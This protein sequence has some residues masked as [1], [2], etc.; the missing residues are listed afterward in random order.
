MHRATGKPHVCAHVFCFENVHHLTSQFPKVLECTCER[1]TRVVRQWCACFPCSG[2]LSDRAYH[3]KTHIRTL[4]PHMLKLQHTRG[5]LLGWF[6]GFGLLG[7]ALVYLLVGSMFRWFHGSLVGL[8]LLDMF[9]LVWFGLVCLDWLFAVGWL[10]WF[11]CWLLLAVVGCGRLH[12]L[13]G[14]FSGCLFFECVN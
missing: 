7:V 6:I 4:E 13:V 14:P 12:W 8:G 3:T 2:Q 9:G 1:T 11:A 5:W 10:D